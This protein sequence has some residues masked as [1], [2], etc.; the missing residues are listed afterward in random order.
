MDTRIGDVLEHAG[1]QEEGGDGSRPEG[2][3]G[4]AADRRKSTRLTIQFEG[5]FS[6]AR[7]LGGRGI[8]RELSRRGCRVASDTPVPE[9][10]E[11]E[12]TIHLDAV[13]DP[14][15]VELAVVRWSKGNEFGLEF[16]VTEPQT[17]AR[18]GRFLAGLGT[19]ALGHED[20]AST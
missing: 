5:S 15:Q 1:L 10:V 8:V 17:S 18:L 12:A 2:G 3:P 4:P 13:H 14:V 19:D 11:L 6:S 9:R 16:I 7:M 20:R